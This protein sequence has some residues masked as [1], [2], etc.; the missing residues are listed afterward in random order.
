[1]GALGT[2][3]LIVLILT[4]A[5]GFFAASE[6]GI[7]SARRSRLE[8]Q[9]AAG[10]RRARQAIAL[11]DQPDRFLA[12]V[13]V[14]ISLIGTFSAAFGGAR[15]GDILTAWFKGIP[16]VSDY[17]EPLALGIVVIGITYLSLILG[18]LVPKRLALQYA[19][20]MAMLSAPVMTMIALIARPI[21]GFLTFSVQLVLRLI[22]QRAAI[23]NAVTQEDIEYLMREG[24]ASGS[25]EAGEVQLMESVFR[26]RD[27]AVRSAMTPRTEVVAIDA[28]TS[29]ADAVAIV[30]SSGYSRLPVYRSS[31]DQV[32]GV[33]HSKDVIPLLHSNTSVKLADLVRPATFV[34]A[35]Q[36]V[37]DLLP[38]FRRNGT[39]MGMVVDEYGQIAGII[40]L[41]DVL[42]E[43]VG[44][45]KDEHDTTEEPAMTRREDGSWLVDGLTPYDQVLRRIKDL[46]PP[47]AHEAGEYTTLAGLILTRLNAIPVVGNMVTAGPYILEVIDMDERRIDKVLIRRSDPPPAPSPAPGEPAGKP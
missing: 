6:I 37:D 18:E 35:T 21:V 26:F 27:R 46:P 38:M 15:I 31:L 7:V 41:E 40:T 42:E 44:E 14:G 3:L 24:V 9:A 29:F 43:L 11:A 47:P 16:A 22:G 28:G 10:S 1:M 39:H 12:T 23:D 8:Q 17:A 25:V 4:L 2:E 45:I 34:L 30:V 13:Q 32:V 5:N 33:L 19:E 20:R 36:H